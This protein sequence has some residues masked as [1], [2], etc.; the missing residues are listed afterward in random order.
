[1]DSG[2]GASLGDLL[3]ALL[4]SNSEYSVDFATGCLEIGPELGILGGAS[5]VAVV[6]ELL[7]SWGLEPMGSWPGEPLLGFAFESG[8]LSPAFEPALEPALEPFLEPALV[9]VLVVF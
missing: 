6:L 7:G 2:S 9:P 4:S 5:F 8:L 1:M 3:L